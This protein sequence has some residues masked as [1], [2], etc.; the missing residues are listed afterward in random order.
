MSDWLFAALAEHDPDRPAVDT[1]RG[2]LTY[3]WL[4]S[5][6]DQLASSTDQS[7]GSARSVVVLSQRGEAST[8]IALL[9]IMRSGRVPLML[10]ASA[11]ADRVAALADLLGA[12]VMDSAGAVLR[13]ARSTPQVE[14]SWA[15]DG[16]YL[17]STSGSTAAPRVVLCRW[18]GLKAV[19]HELMHRYYIDETSRVLQFAAPSYDAYMADVIPVL[20]AGGVS[21]C[22]D[23]DG[24]TTPRRLVEVIR[25]RAVTHATFPPSY[26]KRL[27]SHLDDVRLV[28]LVSAGEVLD[29]FL[30]QRL[31][32]V[33]DHL[34]NAYGP[35]EATICAATHEIDAD[36]SLTVPVGTPLQGVSIDLVDGLI[37][38]SGPTVAWGYIGEEVGSAAFHR[39]PDGRDTF[40]TGDLGRIRD[41]LLYVDGRN[42]RQRKIRGHLV[43]LS[44]L[45]HRLEQIAGVSECAAIDLG[46][47]LA[48]VVVGSVELDALA[49]VARS[50]LPLSELPSRWARLPQLP[51]LTSDKLDY[52]ALRA[53]F[54]AQSNGSNGAATAAGSELADRLCELWTEFALLPDG[55]ATDF[56]SQGGTSLAAMEMLDRVFETVG[57]EVDLADFLEAP[58]FGRLVSLVE[59]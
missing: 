59:G 48:A 31:S 39:P 51:Y 46:D 43:D 19:S 53:V 32:G 58:T 55:Q 42:D 16:A 27:V 45:E 44:A 20:L 10:D 9:A 37:R 35:C 24:W 12:P 28:T 33:A 34:I 2:A 29:G 21:V 25:G 14:V 26:L 38:I 40:T 52:M 56:F 54:A 8:I 5:T 1:S 47:E 17:V 15:D 30:A 22:C 49:R 7:L 4:L 18:S 3:R 50:T 6:I 57:V 41:G 23:G 11:Q 36:V 13:H